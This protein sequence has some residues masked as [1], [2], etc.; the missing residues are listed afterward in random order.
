MGY[1]PITVSGSSG[2]G[3]FAGGGSLDASELEAH[4]KELLSAIAVIKSSVLSVNASVQSNIS[5]CNSINVSLGTDAHTKLDK[6]QDILDAIKDLK[7]DV[8]KCND[9]IGDCKSSLTNSIATCRKDIETVISNTKDTNSKVDA[10]LE[11]IKKGDTAI[12]GNLVSHFNSEWVPMRDNVWNP[13]LKLVQQVTSQCGSI[14]S[15]VNALGEKVKEIKDNVKKIK[16][17]VEDEL[18]LFL[19]RLITGSVKSYV[20]PLY[21]IFKIKRDNIISELHID[22]DGVVLQPGGAY[23]KEQD[24]TDEDWTETAVSVKSYEPEQYGRFFAEYTTEEDAQFWYS[25][26]LK[27]ILALPYRVDGSVYFPKGTGNYLRR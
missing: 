13:G 26:E 8:K 12:L 21:S 6:F 17:Q 25:E 7:S 5:V 1:I 14:L 19:A 4:Q 22:K 3:G 20:A 18:R 23:K 27:R 9:A 11:W 24:A 10:N 2:C 16:D 15:V